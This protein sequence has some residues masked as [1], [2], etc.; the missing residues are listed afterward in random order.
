M[1]IAQHDDDLWALVR[2]LRAEVAQLGQAVAEVRASEDAHRRWGA[3]IIATV[4]GAGA[5]MAAT[6]PPPLRRARGLGALW[7][8]CESYHANFASAGA[9]LQSLPTSS[10]LHVDDG[11]V[12]SAQPF[13]FDEVQL[14]VGV[15]CF[16]DVQ[17]TDRAT[18]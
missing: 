17:G 3:S 5:T 11:P 4:R 15:D 10:P 2:D 8:W 7:R 12:V 6:A 16:E 18:G 14:G 13:G 9:T 1:T